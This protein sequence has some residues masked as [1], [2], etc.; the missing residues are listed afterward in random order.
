[1]SKWHDIA[2]YNAKDSAVTIESWL[3]IRKQLE[4]KGQWHTHQFIVSLIE[5][6]TYISSRGIKIDTAGM[7][8]FSGELEQEYRALDIT[9]Q[10]IVGRPLNPGSPKQLQT[11]FYVE[12]KEKPY[13][14]RSTG[15]MT[16]DEEALKK[17]ARKGYE[18]AK[19]LLAMRG[20]RKLKSSYLDV[21]YDEDGRM[22][23][24]YNP[25][26]TTTGRLSSSKTIFGAGLNL[27]TVPKK[28]RGFF[29]ADPGHTLMEVDLSQAEARV[30]ALLAGDPAMLG[31][32]QS[33]GDIHQLTADRVG[34]DRQV[35]KT[36]NHASNYGLGSN[37]MSL[38][39][40]CTKKEAE[41]LMN[42]YHLIY[43]GIKSVF[44][45][46][47]ED[48][49]R[50]TRTLV[51]LFG[52]KRFFMDR[53]DNN[54]LRAGYSFIPQSTVADLTN[55]GLRRL[56][57]SNRFDL[58]AQVHDSVLMQ[59]KDPGPPDYAFIRKCME[60]PL[61]YRGRQLV[62]PAEVKVGPNWRDMVDA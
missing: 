1:M 53:W 39:L 52:R 34:C 14:S 25:A 49:L 56:Y 61:E 29:V 57:R 31:V 10:E 8:K 24:S 17:L 59:M 26:G 36:L 50:R 60:E 13:I 42:K 43:P 46:G 41:D 51:N 62:I 55:R 58:L 35:A 2:V 30:V 16:V 15:R 37:K 6:L 11:Y 23:C 44:Q 38:M 18:E 20:I 7:R 32:F 22:R 21:K 12:K 48:E 27:Q 5:P 45:Q 9:L 54:L 3:E 28:A 40:S 47:V 33:G 19:L 4:E